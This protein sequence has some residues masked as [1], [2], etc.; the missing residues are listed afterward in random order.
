M[1]HSH[2][3]GKRIALVMDVQGHDVVVH[4]RSQVHQDRKGR[5]VLEVTVTGDREVTVGDPVFFIAED[6]WVSGISEGSAMGC[7]YC[8]HLNS[9]A[10]AAN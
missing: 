9:A 4:G 2:Y 10:V 6:R 1:N 3:N 8:L 7:D 5:W